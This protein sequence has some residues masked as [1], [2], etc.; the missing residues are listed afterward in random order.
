M[1][2]GGSLNLMVLSKGKGMTM[3]DRVF[4]SF[5]WPL[6]MILAAI[7]NITRGK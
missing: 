4:H 1:W 7:V 6:W 5:T 3:N 2:A